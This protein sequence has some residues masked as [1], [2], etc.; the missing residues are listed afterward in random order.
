MMVAAAD[1]HANPAFVRASCRLVKVDLASAGSPESWEDLIPEHD[2]DLLQWASAHEVS[3][4]FNQSPH[5]IQIRSLGHSSTGAEQVSVGFPHK[6][7]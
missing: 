7:R 3:R 6:V 4:V 2:T 5:L 1:N